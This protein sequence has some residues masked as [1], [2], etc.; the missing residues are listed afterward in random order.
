MSCEEL[1]EC[2][3]I[4]I[5]DYEFLPVYLGYFFVALS[6]NNYYTFICSYSLVFWFSYLSQMQYYNP[7]FLIL[8]YHYY[9]VKTVSGTNVFILKRGPIIRNANVVSFNSL[10]RLNDCTYIEKR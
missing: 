10:R 5:A 8:G 9:N 3:E 7:V 6:T 4:S 2:R 1:N